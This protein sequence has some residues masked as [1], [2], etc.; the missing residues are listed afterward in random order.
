MRIACTTQHS[1]DWFAA[2]TGKIGASNVWKVMDFLKSGKES[3]QRANYRAEMIAEV[4]TGLPTE[5]YV[6]PAMDHGSEYE[7]VARAEYQLATGLDVT[8]TGFLLHPTIDRAGASPDGLCDPDGMIEAKC[9]N[10]AT[11]LKWITAGEV[12]Q[13]HIDQ[14]QFGMVCGEMQWCDFISFDPRLPEKYRLF[15]RRLQR[16]D[17]RIAEIEVGIGKFLAEVLETIQALDKAFPDVQRREP[18]PLDPLSHDFDFLDG[19]ALVP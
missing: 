4:L 13:E 3:Q 17:A 2:R 8:Q 16:D 5:H 18:K 12:P 15:I 10:T 7:K 1:T 11:H 6:S 19:V 9:P 14:M